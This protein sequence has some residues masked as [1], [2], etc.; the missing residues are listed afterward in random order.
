MERCVIRVGRLIDH[1]CGRGK[2]K[3][4]KKCGRGACRR[5]RNAKGYCLSC[6]GELPATTASLKL[7]DLGDPMDFAPE[8]YAAFGR[9]AGAPDDELA[10]VDS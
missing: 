3:A 4:C 6:A 5:H 9:R 1:P 2:A 7:E 10:G 8:V